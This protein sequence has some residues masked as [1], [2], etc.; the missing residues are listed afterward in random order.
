[1]PLNC[2]LLFSYSDKRD[3]I[4]DLLNFRNI[5]S[6][7]VQRVFDAGNSYTPDNP[8]GVPPLWTGAYTGIVINGVDFG[9][10]RITSFSNPTSADITENG[11]NLWKQNVNVEVFSSGDLSNISGSAMVGVAGA[12]SKQLSSLDEIFAFDISQNGDYQYNHQTNVK[13]SDE[14]NGESGYLIA[15]RIASGLAASQ[16][17][18]GY[19][20]V[21]HSGFHNATGRRVYSETTDV[22]NGTASISERFLIQARN[23]VKH[24]VSFN[25]GFVNVTEQAVLR[26]SGISSASNV[27]NSDIDPY[28]IT[29]RL[30]SVLNGA[31]ARCSGLWTTYRTV[32]GEDAYEYNLHTQPS[33]ITKSFNENS[34]EM[35]Y[36]I[37]YT[38]NPIMSNNYTIS[39]EQAI[40]QSIQGIIEASEQGSI[41]AYN[42]KD[43]TLRTVL[44]AALT[45]EMTNSKARIAEFW[46]SASS[47]K[48]L[49]ENKSLSSR[50]KEAKYSISFTNDPSFIYDGVYLTKVESFQDNEAIRMHA[51]YLVPGRTTPLMHNPGQT[52]MGNASCTISATLPRQAGYTPDVPVKPTSTLNLMFSDA[53]NRLLREIGTKTPLDVFVSKVSYNY[54]QNMGAELMAE[55]QYIYPRLDVI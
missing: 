1:M 24:S 7:Q 15:K 54:N 29:T 25:D 48:T 14:P 47:L 42:P 52:Q 50:G 18:F 45:S 36:S 16:P 39:R 33:Q 37:I 20:D 13:C 30:N 9:T 35:A 19:I 27:F 55:A 8:S 4:G 6:M 2:N 38:N 17:P 49:S 43:A 26:H 11:R 51:P 32:L 41:V 22:I 31:Y 12:Y 44:A 40:N 10:G 53:I 28:S 5:T 23:F 34:Q 21:I 46:S 3:Y